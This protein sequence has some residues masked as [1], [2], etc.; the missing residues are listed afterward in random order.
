[1]KNEKYGKWFIDKAKY[2]NKEVEAFRYNQTG[3]DYIK[4][5]LVQY[6]KNIYSPSLSWWKK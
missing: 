3:I 4:Q 5:L 1:M 6:E 2:T